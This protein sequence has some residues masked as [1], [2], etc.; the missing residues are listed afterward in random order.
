MSNVNVP[1][2]EPGTSDAGLMSRIPSL[3]FEFV[4]FPSALVFTLNKSV[5]APPT[6]WDCIGGV[7]AAE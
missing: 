7:A 1:K 5:L 2:S 6:N 4:K 3:N